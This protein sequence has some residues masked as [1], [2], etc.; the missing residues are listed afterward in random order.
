MI[1]MIYMI[2]IHVY[3]HAGHCGDLGCYN[4]T[5]RYGDLCEIFYKL[6]YG[7]FYNVS[8]VRT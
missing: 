1:Y 6:R 7:D 4:F 2:Y 5:L 3:L 8:I